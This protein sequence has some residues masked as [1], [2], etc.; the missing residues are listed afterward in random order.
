MDAVTFVAVLPSIFPDWTDRCVESMAPE[1]MMRTLIVDNTATNIGVSASWNLGVEAMYEEGTD[2]LVIISAS[3]IFCTADGGK[4]F[5]AELVDADTNV[6][7]EAGHGIGWHCIAFPRRVF[8]AIGRFDNNL[9]YYGD[10]DWAHRMSLAFGL[11]PPYWHKA[12]NTGL[13]FQGFAHGIDLAGVRPD[14]DRLFGYYR[15]KWGSGPGGGEHFDH[16]FNDGA[17]GVDWWPAPPDPRSIL[18]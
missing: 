12:N 1:L 9:S 18:T 17:H 15:D 2:W 6:A 10:N 13:A 16:P 5:L 8:D 7:I 3:M 11:D 14:N 4:A